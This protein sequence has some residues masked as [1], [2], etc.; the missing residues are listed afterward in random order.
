MFFVCTSAEATGN[1][2]H[3]GAVC[4]EGTTAVGLL[5]R[6]TAAAV[7]G[8]L[9]SN[10]ALARITRWSFSSPKDRVLFFPSQMA[11]NWLINGGYSTNYL[12]SNG[13][14]S[15]TL[16][17]GRNFF[18]EIRPVWTKLLCQRGCLRPRAIW[19][20]EARCGPNKIG[21]RKVAW[22]LPWSSSYFLV[23]LLLAQTKPMFKIDILD[24][25]IYEY[26]YDMINGLKFRHRKSFLEIICF[27]YSQTPS[28]W[29]N[30]VSHHWKFGKSMDSK[31]PGFGWV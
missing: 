27:I 10:A 15:S 16:L 28:T 2:G 11:L 6:A 1:V 26:L 30:G 13:A 18:V 23:V 4:L 17:T 14:P 25:Y 7:A 29:K 31:V 3:V 8:S 12:T 20:L 22:C 24:I 21:V 19:R 9:A 5:R